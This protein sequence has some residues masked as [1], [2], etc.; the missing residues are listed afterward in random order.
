FAL[1][2]RRVTISTAGYAPGIRRL[3][4]EDLPVRLALSLHATDNITRSRLMPINRK[5]PIEEVLDACS[6]LVRNRRTPLTLEYML[7]RGENDS[8]REAG[9]LTKISLS[10]GAKVN[11]IEYNPVFPGR[12]SAPPRERTLQFQTAL[13]KAGVMA[14]IRRSRGLDVEGACGQLRASGPKRAEFRVSSSESR[15]GRRRK[16]S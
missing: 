12:F 7:I 2:K 5:Y 8:L 16:S 15:V 10:L 6:L 3:A 4:D 11:L 1:G 9:K 14:F 13:R